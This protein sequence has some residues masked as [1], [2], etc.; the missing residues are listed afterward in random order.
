MVIFYPDSVKL[1]STECPGTPSVPCEVLELTEMHLPGLLGTGIKGDSDFSALHLIW[2]TSLR[3]LIPGL[4]T[5]L[6]LG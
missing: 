5:L 4:K 1:F 2:Q 3:S 6:S